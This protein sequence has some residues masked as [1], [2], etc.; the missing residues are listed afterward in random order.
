MPCKSHKGHGRVFIATRVQAHSSP[1][2]PVLQTKSVWQHQ[3]EGEHPAQAPDV[4]LL[5]LEG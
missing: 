5:A 4:T 1:A 3:R 2:E